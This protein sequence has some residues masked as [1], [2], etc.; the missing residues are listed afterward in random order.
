MNFAEALKAIDYFFEAGLCPNLIG[1]TGIGKTELLAQYTIARNMDLI[2]LQVSQIEPSDFVGL[3]KVDENNRT[4]TCPPNWLPHI[5]A[6]KGKQPNKEVKEVIDK[7]RQIFTGEINPNGGVIFLDEINRG[8]EDIRQALYQLVNERRIHTYV[9]PDNYYVAAACNPS[10]E[11]Y[12]VAEFDD[13]LINRFAWLKFRPEVS[14]TLS[15]LEGKYGKN[16]HVLA[17]VKSTSGDMIDYGADDWEVK[18]LRYSP[19]IMEKSIRLHETTKSHGETKEFRRKLFSCFMVEEQVGSLIGFLDKMDY[20]NFKNV[21]NGSKKKDAQKLIDDKANGI[22]LTIINNLADVF[23][24]YKFGAEK[25]N[26]FFKYKDED[27]VAERVTA[28]IGACGE[29]YA[30]AFLNNIGDS[31][32]HDT[33][34]RSIVWTKSFTQNIGKDVLNEFAKATIE[35]SKKR[36]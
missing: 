5:E 23:R 19:R 29:E 18:G 28:F 4:M 35:A 14:E 33:K 17:W 30:T 27:I 32:F 21:I 36:K 1:E 26:E 22:I 13:A 31:N 11:G 24:N 6:A 9:L 25:D 12:E 10:S 7:L 8:H 2:P 16:N 3:Y 20:I 15:Y 34:K